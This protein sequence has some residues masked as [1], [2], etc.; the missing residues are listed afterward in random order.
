MLHLSHFLAFLLCKNS[1]FSQKNCN[2]R[3]I[4]KC[5]SNPGL[6]AQQ[7]NFVS[8]RVCFSNFRKFAFF[9]KKILQKR[10]ELNK[11]VFIRK[12]SIFA[13]WKLMILQS[14]LDLPK[15]IKTVEQKWKT[16]KTKPNLESMWP[17]NNK[18]WRGKGKN[19]LFLTTVS[20]VAIYGRRAKRR[21]KKQK[22]VF[23]FNFA[24]NFCR[25]PF[26]PFLQKL[27]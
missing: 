4:V 9:F 25:L 24:T 21:K 7:W 6:K 5:H 15:S 12:F 3:E 27:G 11:K 23:F 10:E 2:L 14:P 13:H 20:P 18:K 1:L 26:I 8:W 19:R 22:L 16:N 17:V